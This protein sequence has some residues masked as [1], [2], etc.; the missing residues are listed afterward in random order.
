MRKPYV[1]GQF[2]PSGKKA[3]KD[4]IESCYLHRLGPGKIPEIGKDRRIVGAVVPH[5]GYMYSGP[6]AAFAYYEIGSDGK[7][8]TFVIIGPNHRGMGPGIALSS[9]SWE[10]P[11]GRVNTDEEFVEDLSSL[12]FDV[13]DDAHMYEHSLEVQL[14]FLQELYGDFSIV[15]ITTWMQDFDTC[16]ELGE[17]ISKVTKKLGRETIVLASTD[18]SHYEPHEVA[19]K[20]DNIAIKAIVDMDPLK[21]SEVVYSE[22]ISMCGTGPTIS[23][24]IASKELG[25]KT[26]SLLKY[27]TSGDITGDRSRV[28]GYASIV[29]RR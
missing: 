8:E 5:A 24:L 26:S 11:L 28:V 7:P 17:A 12:G 16:K 20:K 3:L 18:F 10:T 13:D 23:A 22:S 14:P 29:M 19:R 9:E 21:L 15:A 4:A 25:A 27:A 6:V 1:A 2:Y